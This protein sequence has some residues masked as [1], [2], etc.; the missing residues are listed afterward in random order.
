MKINI[1]RPGM[2]HFENK[3]VN[4]TTTTS[5][6]MIMLQIGWETVSQK[7]SVQLNVTEASKMRAIFFGLN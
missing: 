6:K 4:H 2:A 1:K 7:L 3:N 5:G